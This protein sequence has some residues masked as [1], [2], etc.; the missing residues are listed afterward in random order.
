MVDKTKGLYKKFEVKRVDQ[1]PK[2]IGCDYFVLDLTHD[3]FALIVIKAY[4]EACKLEYPLLADDI[5]VKLDHIMNSA[6]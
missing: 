1:S 4:A 3:P 6:I 5:M 2:H